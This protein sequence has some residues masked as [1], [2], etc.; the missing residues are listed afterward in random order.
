MGGCSDLRKLKE[1]RD[2]LVAAAQQQHP[3]LDILEELKYFWY[4]IE[5]FWMIEP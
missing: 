3:Q 4:S 2:P 5:M 1:S